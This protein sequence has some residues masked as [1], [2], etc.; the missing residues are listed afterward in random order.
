M[1]CFFL[2]IVSMHLPC[3]CQLFSVFF[4]PFSQCYS[5]NNSSVGCFCYTILCNRVDGFVWHCC[6]CV[7]CILFSVWN[8]SVDDC[9]LGS[10]A[11]SLVCSL[12]TLYSTIV[13]VMLLCGIRTMFNFA[14]LMWNYS[15]IIVIVSKTLHVMQTKSLRSTSYLFVD[16]HPNERTQIKAR[17]SQ[18]FFERGQNHM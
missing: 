8:S 10:F 11:H 15:N 2:A 3:F 7:W 5:N 12:N 9:I 1:V 14:C 4:P 6:L 13:V 18:C 17:D 16:L